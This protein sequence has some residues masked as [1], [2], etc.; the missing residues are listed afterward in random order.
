MIVVQAF[1]QEE[2]EQNRF[3]EFTRAVIGAQKRST[4][5]ESI[6]NLFADGISSIGTAVILYLG[7][8]HVINGRLT[9]GSLLVFISYLGTLQWQLKSFTGIYSALQAAGASVDRV[10][11]ILDTEGEVENRV[12]A[13]SLSAVE[14]HI[15][16]ENVSFGYETN[17]PILHENL[18]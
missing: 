5:T 4:L 15:R 14:G 10:M 12:G 17:R 8:W 16:F 11:E 1:G 9:I 6:Y 7:A 3:R 18:F 13:R 2:R